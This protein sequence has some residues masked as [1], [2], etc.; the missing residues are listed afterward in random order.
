VAAGEVVENDGIVSGAR[1][2]T[3]GVAADVAGTACYE[4]SCHEEEELLAGGS[5]PMVL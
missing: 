3:Q 4:K 2:T 5:S 1:E